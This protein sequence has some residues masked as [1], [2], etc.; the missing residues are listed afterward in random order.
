MVVS[1]LK[2][3]LISTSVQGVPSQGRQPHLSP[4]AEQVSTTNLYIRGLPK[5]YTDEVLVK[6]CKKYVCA[7]E[8]AF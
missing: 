5:V 1:L 2:E 6:L 8:I 3:S 4:P 7:L